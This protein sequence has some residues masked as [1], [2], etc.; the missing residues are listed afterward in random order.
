MTVTYDVWPLL[1]YVK[2]IAEI[3]VGESL[4]ISAVNLLLTASLYSVHPLI[5]I[6]A[7][8]GLPPL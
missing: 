2:M 7:H 6:L 8:I 1:R 4:L 5:D 3:D